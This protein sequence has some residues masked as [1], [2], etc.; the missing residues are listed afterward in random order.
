VTARPS[1]FRA[2]T[3][4]PRAVLALA[5]VTAMATTSLAGAGTS[6]AVA[7]RPAA[8]AV[9]PGL[10]GTP[11]LL[12]NRVSFDGDLRAYS[13]ASDKSGKTYIAWLASSVSASGGRELHFCTLLLHATSCKGGVQTIGLTDPSTSAGI[14]L[15]VTPGGAV[16]ILWYHTDS[17][18]G[19]I[20]EATSQS[21]GPLSSEH[22][23]ASAPVNGQLLDAEL[24]P[25]GSI[26]TVA[27]PS[28][29]SSLEVRAG[30]TNPPTTVHTPYQVGYAQLAFAGSTPILAITKSAAI[31]Q[32]AAYASRPGGSWTSFKN[33]PETGTAGQDVALVHTSS[34]VRLITDIG[35][36]GYTPVTAKWNGHGFTHR[37]PT[38]DTCILGSHDGATDS[39][40]R[41]V[42]V[43][44]ECNKIAVSN[45][46][47]GT[48][49]AI[50]RFSA[51]GLEAG[52]QPQIASVPRGYAWVAWSTELG[53]SGLDGDN[54][55][56]AFVRLA[57]VYRSVSHRG[58]HGSVTVT[59]PATCLP[60]DSI[61][62][63]VKGHPNHGWR[64]ASRRLVLGRKKV[65]S[66]LNGA[67]LAAGR[68]Y[69]LKG[70]VVFAS[71]S[72]H[73][74]VSATVK[75]RTCPNP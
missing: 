66:T 29:G 40:G 25:D 55:K 17:G 18:G 60:A 57:G 36:A 6:A 43:A 50:I 63:S 33:V 20:A 67:T 22:D 54:L 56:V 28:S 64:V 61:S 21:G 34:G 32:A 31:T 23:V 65:G 75:F 48:H 35:D 74:T 70:L 44:N 59:G 11:I 16:T 62:V 4:A 49:A 8:S 30:I 52:G 19:E 14:R 41:L 39:S 38:G 24:A 58:S 45:L 73:E 42:D 26:W 47:A 12:A 10:A 9:R 15:L 51:G 2:R 7:A 27:E 53:T 69:S 46:G 13:L 72:S 3:L 37:T 71:G 1:L 5:V 68:A